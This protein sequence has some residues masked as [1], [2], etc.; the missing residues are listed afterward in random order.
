MLFESFVRERSGTSTEWSAKA[1]ELEVALAAQSR[2][3]ESLKRMVTALTSAGQ[4]KE[5]ELAS[6]P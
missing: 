4:A 5:P 6:K 1:A 3:I 2:E